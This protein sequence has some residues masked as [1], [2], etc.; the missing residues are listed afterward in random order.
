[1]VE[2]TA[3]QRPTSLAPDAPKADGLQTGGSDF[4]DWNIWISDEGRWWATRRNP[5]PPSSWTPG[6]AL[7]VTADDRRS[8]CL[9]IS[10]QPDDG[11]VAD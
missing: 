4:P 11:Q 5:L 1:M 3:T 8:L 6:Y 9:E 2:L 10:H 7:T